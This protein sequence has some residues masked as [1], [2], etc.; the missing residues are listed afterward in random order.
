MIGVMHQIMFSFLIPLG[1]VQIFSIDAIQIRSFLSVLRVLGG[2]R[3]DSCQSAH[4]PI[5]QN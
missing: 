3:F 1:V 5:A 4:I 2:E